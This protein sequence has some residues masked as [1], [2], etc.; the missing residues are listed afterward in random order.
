MSSWQQLAHTSPRENTPA[1]TGRGPNAANIKN[2]WGVAPISASKPGAQT[3]WREQHHQATRYLKRNESSFKVCPSPS[4]PP[5]PPRTLLAGE[6][7]L[8]P[9]PM[10]D[11]P[12]TGPPGHPTMFPHPSLPPRPIDGRP[13]RAFLQPVPRPPSPPRTFSF[14]LADVQDEPSLGREAEGRSPP[15]RRPAPRLPRRWSPSYPRL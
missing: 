3:V 11:N 2:L 12:T 6:D 9:P 13:F 1:S 10:T 4:P 15:D 7:S 5:P 14:S 8:L